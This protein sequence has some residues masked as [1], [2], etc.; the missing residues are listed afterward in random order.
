MRWL[1]NS[2]VCILILL[3][4]D[5]GFA[6]GPPKDKSLLVPIEGEL[7]PI[8]ASFVKEEIG[9]A[10]KEK[11]AF[12]ILKLSLT[13]DFSPALL[14][15]LKTIQNSKLPIVA[16]VPRQDSPPSLARTFLLEASHL[17]A[18]APETKFG[19]APPE[20]DLDIPLP[21]EEAAEKNKTM[22]QQ[23]ALLKTL[24][25]S[26]GRK[27]TWVEEVV[28][29]GKSFSAEEAINLGAID[30][31]AENLDTLLEKANGRSVHVLSQTIIL[32]TQ[33]LELSESEVPEILEAMQTLA[34]PEITQWVV[35]AGIVLLLLDFLV[36]G[37]VVPGAIGLICLV[38]ML[39]ASG[40]ISPPTAGWTFIV[41]G[42]L[43]LFLEGVV[44]AMGLIAICGAVSL[45]FG[46]LILLGHHFPDLLISDTTVIFAVS[47]GTL[48]SI[49]LLSLIKKIYKKFNKGKEEESPA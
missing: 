8:I 47:L 1:L 42:L 44:A 5:I 48:F 36:F 25:S 29:E 33:K 38:L 10:Q 24:A 23:T 43:L 20:D 31:A 28:R 49:G 4:P 18:M 32:N 6:E 27:T 3:T 21:P 9:R 34:N 16:F 40:L 19:R 37:A 14:H 2:M 41:M 7:N 45:I 15:T 46:I 11:F 13:G 17:A 26:Q 35:I 22:I 30:L 12:V 39:F